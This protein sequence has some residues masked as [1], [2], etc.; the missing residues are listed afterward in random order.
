MEERVTACARYLATCAQ[1]KRHASTDSVQK[2]VLLAG[3]RRGSDQKWRHF[4]PLLYEE[5]R[6]TRVLEFG[7]TITHLFP[8]Q[9]DSNDIV[10]SCPNQVLTY[11]DALR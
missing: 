9:H 5:H 1:A 6:H 8:N 2:D 10:K 4:N 3:S 11:D 7:K